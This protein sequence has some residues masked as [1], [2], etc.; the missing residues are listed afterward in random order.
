[1]VEGQQQFDEGV[2]GYGVPV[3]QPQLLDP[4]SQ[5]AAV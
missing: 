2:I 3:D 5:A 1:M 4:Y